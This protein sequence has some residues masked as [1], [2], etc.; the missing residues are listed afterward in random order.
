MIV[1]VVQRVTIVM[2]PMPVGARLGRTGDRERGHRK[3]GNRS[4]NR[5]CFFHNRSFKNGTEPSQSYISAIV[6]TGGHPVRLRCGVD[7]IV[8]RRAPSGLSAAA[9]RVES[10]PC[11][12]RMDAVLN[13]YFPKMLHFSLS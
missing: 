5:C 2:M 13:R 4:Q 1:V 3:H 6:S 8:S 11:R 12:R 9:T 7:V 10:R